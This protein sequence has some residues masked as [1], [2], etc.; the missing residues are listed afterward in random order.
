M[1]TQ[2]SFSGEKKGSGSALC[3]GKSKGAGSA[4]SSFPSSLFPTLGDQNVEE[5]RVSLTGE[6]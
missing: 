5:G 4:L 1:I 2:G 6:C 3:S